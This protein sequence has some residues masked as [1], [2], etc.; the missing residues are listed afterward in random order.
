MAKP[1]IIAVSAMGFL[2]EIG[3]VVC[4][5]FYK[6]LLR[7]FPLGFYMLC[8]AIT[9]VGCYSCISNFGY[10][11]KAYVYFYYY[12][13]ALMTVLMFWV[14]IH[15]YRQAFDEL[16]VSKIIR[17][18][19]V[20]LLISTA[21]FSYIVVN[22]NKDHLTDRFVIELSQ[23]LYFIGVVLTYLLWGT[24]LKLRETRARLVQLVLA[25]G[26]YFSGTAAAYALRN[27][28]PGFGGSLFG[29]VPILMST[30]LAVAWMYTFVKVPEESRVAT[31]QIEARAAA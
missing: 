1:I 30:W 25:L 20:F 18:G 10:T 4:M 6:S 28:F 7:Y 23:N 29:W 13:D 15:F 22:K 9:T 3:V 5:L 8:S 17:A 21:L 24:I 16:R 11:S 2:L 14:V 26:I 27:L 31:A 12:S 19:A